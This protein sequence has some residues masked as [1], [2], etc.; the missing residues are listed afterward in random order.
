MQVLCMAEV[1]AF[2]DFARCGLLKFRFTTPRTPCL[3]LCSSDGIMQMQVGQVQDEW[4]FRLLFL[5]FDQFLLY[6]V[7]SK[8]RFGECE[9]NILL[10]LGF[11]S[12]LLVVDH[13]T[14]RSK[15]LECT[16]GPC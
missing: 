5:K 7:R 13:F 8:Y 12:P 1:L 15:Y 16:G 10:I 14:G 9:L 4:S 2:G 6:A 3:Q 11:I